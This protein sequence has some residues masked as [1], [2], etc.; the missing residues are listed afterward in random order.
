M[1]RYVDDDNVYNNNNNNMYFCLVY[2]L[3]SRSGTVRDVK[4]TTIRKIKKL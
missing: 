4:Q 1:R 2:T 3:F